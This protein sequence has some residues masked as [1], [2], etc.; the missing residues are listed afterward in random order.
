M[1]DVGGVS[2]SLT[3]DRRSSSKQSLIPMAWYCSYGC[4]WCVCVHESVCEWHELGVCVCV[5]VSV[6][7]GNKRV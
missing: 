1:G 5:C 3:V 4:M 6:C 2:F 7:E